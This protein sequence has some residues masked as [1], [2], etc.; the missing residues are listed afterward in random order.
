MGPGGNFGISTSGPFQAPILRQEDL[1]HGGLTASST[2]MPNFSSG[3]KSLQF[4]LQSLRDCQAAGP[5][6]RQGRCLLPTLPR[7]CRGPAALGC[8][9]EQGWGVSI[10]LLPM[11]CPC[12]LLSRGVGAGTEAPGD[13]D[14]PVQPHGGSR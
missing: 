7:L 1:R 12:P 10:G 13:G 8:H 6:P 11:V 14:T 9:W 4:G 3:V 2:R 5:L